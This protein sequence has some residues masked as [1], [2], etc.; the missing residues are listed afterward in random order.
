MIVG[1]FSISQCFR[2]RQRKSAGYEPVS[3]G[4][5][6]AGPVDGTGSPNPAIKPLVAN[7]EGRL[8]I[9]GFRVFLLA[10]PAC[11]DIAGTTYGAR[12][13]RKIPTDKVLD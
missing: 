9:S 7:L 13:C 6:V 4:D 3:A 2:N 12:F 5:D 1:L 8:P 11:C 10:I